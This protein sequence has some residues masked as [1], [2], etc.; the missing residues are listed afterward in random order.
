[1]ADIR[2]GTKYDRLY[3]AMNTPY[4][5]NFQ[6]D[7]AALR[8]FL[9]YFLQP[10]FVSAGGGIIINPEAGEIFYLTRE[11]KQRNVEIAVEECGGKMPVF[12]GVSGLRTE[13]A[14]QV[15]IDAKAAGADGLFLIPPEGS[16]DVAMSWNADRYP[17]VFID[18][19]KPSIDATDLPAI[20]HP[21]APSVGS[22]GMGIPVAATLAICKA[23]PNIVGWKLTYNYIAQ[24]HICRALRTFERHVGL[25]CGGAAWF[26]ENLATRYFDGTVTGS[27][28]YAME[29]IIDHINAWRRSDVNEA[30]RIWKAGLEDFNY[31][32]Y[33]DSSRLHVKYKIA[34]WLRGLIPLPFGRPPMPKPRKAEV[35]QLYD[36][37]VRTGLSV[38]PQADVDRIIKDLPL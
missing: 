7:E 9:R 34:T 8:K 3:V 1:M 28:N 2:F 26:H 22:F 4:K 33:G 19:V 15:A 37:M 5:E 35:T 6:V 36:F 16:M 24:T 12:A 32:V 20:V 21:S 17:E 30:Y 25:L 38:I 27:F 31:Y 10:K 18:F 29:P 13:E 11:E 23:I 14:T